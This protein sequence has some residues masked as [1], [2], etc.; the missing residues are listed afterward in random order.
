M[1]GR[2]SRKEIVDQLVQ[3]GTNAIADEVRRVLNDGGYVTQSEVASA[4]LQMC[5]QTI[6]YSRRFPSVSQEQIRLALQGMIF[7]TEPM[8][9]VH[10][11]EIS[12]VPPVDVAIVPMAPPLVEVE[13]QGVQRAPAFTVTVG[14]E[15]AEAFLVALQEGRPIRVAYEEWNGNVLITSVS[16]SING[17]CQVRLQPT[18]T[19]GSKP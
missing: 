12:P 19:P 7:L 3:A 18:G 6:R 8:G 17:F 15:L 4:F 11:S 5:Q 14:E 10:D 2:A 13:P 16:D 9:S 1:G